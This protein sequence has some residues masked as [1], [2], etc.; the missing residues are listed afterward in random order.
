MQ[1]RKRF[2]YIL[3]WN[4]QRTLFTVRQFGNIPIQKLHT[5]KNDLNYLDLWLDCNMDALIARWV[6]YVYIDAFKCKV[7]CWKGNDVTLWLFKTLPMKKSL[8]L[9]TFLFNLLVWIIIWKF[10]FQ[11]DSWSINSR[12][13]AN[14]I[15]KIESNL[16]KNRVVS[17]DKNSE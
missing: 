3:Y 4:C 8:S 17:P 15:R 6:I 13:P 9:L 11:K 7:D 10:R 2:W 16:N 5:T 12:S 1:E 14:F